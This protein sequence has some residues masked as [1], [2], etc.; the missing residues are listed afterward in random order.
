[1]AMN[2]FHMGKEFLMKKFAFSFWVEVICKQ[3][4][5]QTHNLVHVSFILIIYLLF[6][7]Q[8]HTSH[9]N[10]VFNKRVLINKCNDLDQIYTEY[11]YSYIKGM[12]GSRAITLLVLICR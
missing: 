3:T 1:M 6:S 8:Y 11:E 12:Y 4:H 5:G 10:I 9:K 2:Y 7:N